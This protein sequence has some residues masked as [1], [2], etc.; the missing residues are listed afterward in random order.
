MVNV[1][2]QK[3]ACT[4]CVCIVNVN[5]AVKKDDRNYCSESCAEGHKGGSGCEHQGCSCKG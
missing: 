2:Q 1:T 3:C 5:D 4:D